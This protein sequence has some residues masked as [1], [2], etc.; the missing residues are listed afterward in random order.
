MKKKR[1]HPFKIF[2]HCYF[3]LYSLVCIIP[4]VLLVS[5]SFTDEGVVKNGGYSLI[6]KVFSDAAYKYILQDPA[7]LIRAYGVT[8]VSAFVGTALGMIIMALAGYVLSRDIFILKKAVSTYFLITLLVSGGTIPS[9]IINTQYLHLNNSMWAYVV[10][11]IFNAYT[12]FVF[13][14]FFKGLPNSMIESAEIDGAGEMRILTKIV[15]PLS[16]PVLAS[17]TFI[18]MIGRWNDVS[19][20]LYYITDAKLYNLQ[21]LLQQ[22]LN[23]AEFLKRLAQT[24]GTSDLVTAIPL[25]TLKYA[26]C[27]LAT[28]PMMFAFPFF[29][30]YFT[31]GMVV[32]A[33]KG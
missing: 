11:S 1:I 14:T 7:S 8:A 10:L 4:F 25:E 27:I 31:K 19:I 12:V 18:A 23:E 6:P 13:R 17:M 33:V 9:Y 2:V 28:G 30:K 15:L 32:G 3:I 24:I 21:Y 22:I 5:I 16:T 26:M 29:Q 20:P